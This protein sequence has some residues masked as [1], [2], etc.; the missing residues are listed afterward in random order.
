MSDQYARMIHI[1]LRLVN[2]AFKFTITFCISL[3]LV[4]AI[5]PIRVTAQTLDEINQQIQSTQAQRD[6]YAKQLS[7]AQSL[8]KSLQG[9][10]YGVASDLNTMKTQIADIESRVAQVQTQLSDLTKTVTDTEKDLNARSQVRQEQ[11]AQ[12]FMDSYS[13]ESNKLEM[14]LADTSSITDVQTASAIK[15]FTIDAKKKELDELSKRYLELLD[16]KKEIEDLKKQ[17]DDQ[18]VLLAQK[19]K[20]LEN[21]LNALSNQISNKTYAVKDL[22]GQIVNIDANLASLN[23]TYKRKVDEE[24]ANQ[25][26]QTPVQPG[27]Y[28][29]TGVG[30]DLIDGHGMGFSQWGAYGMSLN[31]WNY[32]Q[33]I[34]FYYPGTVTSTSYP[35]SSDISIIYCSSNPSEYL[36]YNWT[37]CANSG[38]PVV[39]SR[40]S[41][42]TYVSGIGEIPAYFGDEVG[43][44]QT[45]IARTYAIRVTGNGSPTQPICITAQCQVYLPGNTNKAAYNQATRNMLVTYNGSPIVAYF[46][47]SVRGCSSK[48]STVW[49]SSDLPYISIVRDDAVAYKD[50]TSP[51][52]YNPG[53]SIKPYNW[54][55]RTNGYDITQLSHILSLD[56]RTNVGTLQQINTSKDPC[57]RVAQITIVGSNGT[58][59]MTGWT[60][61]SIFNENMDAAGFYDYVYSTDFTFERR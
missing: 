17:L 24:R 9:Q 2:K 29:F 22:S 4:V 35:I 45:I 48:L 33:M 1:T 10:S 44:A 46:T 61:R 47:A 30:R 55:W 23:A 32:Q 50:Y 11:I 31:G 7:S 54:T 25:I 27:Q 14:I 26:R 59:S 43:K 60:F 38:A 49:G 20:D 37:A 53:Q 57:G 39:I 40:I 52:P 8:L 18:N 3:V 56:S 58:K 12:Y 16:Q 42:D 15:E 6:A 13:G 28:Y 5:L 41:M 36:N 21:T 19:K 34:N 51:D